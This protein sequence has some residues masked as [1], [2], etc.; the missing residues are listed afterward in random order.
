MFKRSAFQQ[1]SRG[2]F[3][4]QPCEFSLI[5]D[6]QI[7]ETVE[8]DMSTTIDFESSRKVKVE[9][10]SYNS[11]LFAYFS[12]ELDKRSSIKKL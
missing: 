2:N 10:K 9:F 8:I 5:I 11:N 12:H 3:L 7:V 1:D 4:H 6:D